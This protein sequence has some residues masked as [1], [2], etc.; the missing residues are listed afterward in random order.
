MPT[1]PAFNHCNSCTPGNYQRAV[2]CV[3]GGPE[4]KA[5]MYYDGNRPG[6]ENVPDAI[7]S[8]LSDLEWSWD[9]PGMTEKLET[10]SQQ[11]E[12][13]KILIGPDRVPLPTYYAQNKCNQSLR[14]WNNS[15]VCIPQALDGTISDAGNQTLDTP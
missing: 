14:S 5:R 8:L 4:Q 3:A 15:G 7:E 11:Q 12:A 2:I 6:E 10:I 1:I 13:A 9:A